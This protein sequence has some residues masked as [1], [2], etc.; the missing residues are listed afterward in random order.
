MH[1][2]PEE[3]MAH[4][5]VDAMNVIGSRPDGWWRD[6]DSAVRR[7]IGS[8]QRLAAA[9]GRP[10]TVV[11]DGRP[12][13]DMGEGEHGDVSVLYAW[14]GRNAADDRIVE[15][16]EEAADA[17]AYEVVTSDRGLAERVRACG[18]SVR[19][20]RGLLDELDSLDG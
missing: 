1:E 18:A 20:A 14:P 2:A 12:L 3:S 7:L 15:L 6:R 11:V 5:I 19:G 16:L 8:L 13:A 10:I 17:A 4:L 9:D